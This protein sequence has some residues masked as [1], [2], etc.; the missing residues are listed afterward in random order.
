MNPLVEKLLEVDREKRFIHRNPEIMS[1]M[2][3]F[4]GTR[5][6]VET[7]FAYVDGGDPLDVFL[8]DFPSVSHEQ[9]VAVLKMVHSLNPG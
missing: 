6:P 9:A 1:G 8:Y 4:V 2:P 5:V 3:V 7:L